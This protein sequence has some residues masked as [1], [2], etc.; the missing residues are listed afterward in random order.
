[1]NSAVGQKGSRG[2]VTEQFVRAGVA[3]DRITFYTAAPLARFLEILGSVDVALDTFPCNG[4][5]T[6][7]LALWMGVPMVTL[8]GDTYRSRMGASV[9][10]NLGLPE[11]VAANEGDYVRIATELAG[12]P[13]R[14]AQLRASMR[15]RM[16]E[17]V[18]LD[19]VR[20]AR[21]LEE[22]Y[23]WMMRQLR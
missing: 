5:T 4:H 3:A 9:M 14:L 23:E 21:N 20:F 1:M 22:A 16:R 18:L 13:A 12:D 15:Q 10:T 19:D 8:C 11:L 6:T 2:Y 7:C 17:S